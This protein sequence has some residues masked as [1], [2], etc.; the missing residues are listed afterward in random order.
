M[1]RV[2]VLAGCLLI[3]LPISAWLLASPPEPVP[4]PQVNTPGPVTQGRYQVVFSPWMRADTFLL[5][6]QT[7]RMWKPVQYTDLEGEPTVWQYV[8]RLDTAAEFLNWSRG[9]KSKTE[10]GPDV[11][12]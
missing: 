10:S 6:T 7:G 2:F 4:K 3:A 8:E 11:Q 12:R 9:F 1:R 5:D